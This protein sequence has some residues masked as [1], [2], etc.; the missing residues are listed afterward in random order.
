MNTMPVP[1]C[2]RACTLFVL[3]L[4][5]MGPASA[6]D[7]FNTTA[8]IPATPAAAMLGDQAC[9]PL[10]LPQP[11]PLDV[12]VAQVFC[13]NPK[14]CSAWADVKAAADTL[15]ISR[16]AWLPTLQATTQRIGDH[17]LT[18]VADYSVLKTEHDSSVETNTLALNWV[19]YDFGN[20]S[21]GVDNSRFLLAAARASENEA[22]Q[23]LLADTAKD[24]FDA[25]AA[26]G[27]PRRH[28][29]LAWLCP[30]QPGSRQRPRR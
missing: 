8:D 12:A 23:K 26:H 30:E 15:G 4:L 9:A 18:T 20:H 22:L 13:S 14:T 3:T 11:L 17:S 21:A 25:S 6:L 10:R 7:I 1:K 29:A 16:S 5:T 24:Y 19:L 28:H 27:P 2:Q